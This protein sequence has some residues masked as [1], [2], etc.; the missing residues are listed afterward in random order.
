MLG[1]DWGTK[2]LNINNFNKY[3]SFVALLLQKVILLPGG[4]DGCVDFDDLMKDD[5]NDFPCVQIDPKEDVATIPYTSGTT[6]QS[7]GVII[8]HYNIVAQY[9]Q[10][11]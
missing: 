2:K 3:Y 8:T 7:K 11:T 5:G 1:I 9:L 4:R 10:T 6:G